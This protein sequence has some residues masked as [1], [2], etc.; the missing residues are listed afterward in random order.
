MRLEVRWTNL[1]RR[2]IAARVTELGTPIG[3][4]VASQLLRKHRYRKRKAIKARTMGPRHPDRNAQFENI[5]RLKRQYLAAGLPVVSIDTKKK[6]LI[7]D[8]YRDGQIEAQGAIE[9]ND[10]DFGSMGSG[11]VIP[12][13][14]YDMGLNR[15]FVHLNTSHDTSELACDSPAAW[16]DD[17]GR[18]AYPGATKLLVLC[19]GG[20][21]NSASR[22]VFEEAL[23]ALADR[24]GVE[25]RVAHDPPYCSKYNPIE[26]RLF[27]HVTRACRGVVFRTPE[28]VRHYMSKAGT[29]TGLEVEVR[30]L[31]KV[32]ETGR[33]CAE[34]FKEAMRI[35]F[36]EVLPKW[37]YRAVPG[38]M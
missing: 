3:R 4:H 14:I 9:V 5:S 36:D 38:P 18:S 22:Y 35:V 16:W 33:K 27:P 6:E 17:H 10:H 32:Y 15:G 13:G 28:T 2:Q 31:E 30:I 7:G 8:F 21:S 24:L 1:S 37:N 11:T 20:G 12:H 19:D 25:I 34:G 29:A 23:Q 26:H